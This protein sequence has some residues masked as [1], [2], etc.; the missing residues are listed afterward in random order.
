VKRVISLL[1]LIGI[2]SSCLATESEPIHHAVEIWFDIT[3]HQVRIHDKVSIHVGIDS[4][5]LNSSM[6]IT[7]LGKVSRSDRMLLLMTPVE[8]IPASSPSDSMQSFRT[9]DSEIPDHYTNPY[10]IVEYTGW[11][12]ESTDDIVFSRENVGRE[13]QGTVGE[14]GIYFAAD[15][16]LPY[17]EGVQATHRLTIHTPIGWEPVTQGKRVRH[18]VVGDELITVWDAPNP[19]DGLILVV[20]KYHVTERQFGDVTAY[21]YFLADEPKLVET[22]MERTGAYLEMYGEMI[23]PY[24]YAKFATVENWFPTGYGMPSWT[25]LGGA[26][27]RLPFIPTTSFGHEI[28]HNWWGNSAFVD[29]AEGN[30][31]EGLTV[32]CADYY[33]KSLESDAAAREYR[34]NLLKNYV[35]YVRDDEDMPLSEFR[36][37]HSGA[38]RAIGYGKSMMVFHMVDRTIGRENFLAALRDVW[39]SH[40]YQPVAWSDL[41]NA[42]GHHGDIDLT[43]F[44]DQWLTREG[45]P[46]VSLAAAEV[47]GETVTV[48]LTQDDHTWRTDVPVVIERRDGDIEHIVT[49]AGSEVSMSIEAPGATAVHV[50]PDYHV[51]RRLHPEEIEPT[52]SLILGDPEPRFVLPT[53]L[54]AEAG[55]T[56]AQD[57]IESDDPVIVTAVAPVDG[58]ARIL[59]NPDPAT[60]A[61]LLPAG[62]QV[63][64]TLLFLEGKR[65]DLKK[66]DAVMAVASPD[67]PGTTWLVVICR[68]APRLERLAGRLSHYG[69]Y[70]YLVFPERGRALRGNWPVATSPLST[71]L[72]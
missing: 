13:I 14:E 41:M 71:T 4:L 3:A 59:L 47:D 42:F 50:D 34:R 30:W 49:L 26:V 1:V 65:H 11:L 19:S 57:W 24:P 18:E 48:T 54:L 10:V 20:N 69:K 53:G 62:T 70:S 7:E 36:E 6:Q 40:M 28:A 12:H 16:W 63:S 8:A 21:T 39:S 67:E 72:H 43:G 22:Y 55:R 60:L 64:G 31:C 61:T 56:F 38:T 58:H 66:A 9:A 15:G 32:Y 52:L 25:L 5:M 68:S 2:A 27:L 37:R 23:G 33:Y 35:A 29:D 45:A 17:A 51:F 44:A 46:L